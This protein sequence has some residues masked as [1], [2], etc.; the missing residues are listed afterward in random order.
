MAEQL[1]KTNNSCGCCSSPSN[2]KRADVNFKSNLDFDDIEEHLPEGPL[3][4]D[5]R[6]VVSAQQLHDFAH[7]VSRATL[8]KAN[9]MVY[10]GRVFVDQLTSK[11]TPTLAKEAETVVPDMCGLYVKR[12]N[13]ER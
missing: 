7:S 4:D 10:V 2:K 5:G 3:T 9:P 6:L 1:F 12:E 11:R 8:T 13:Y